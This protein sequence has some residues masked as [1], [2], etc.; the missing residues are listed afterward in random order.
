MTAS[1]TY[2]RDSYRWLAPLLGGVLG[3]C[4]TPLDRFV[5]ERDDDCR[6]GAE[7]GICE[8]SKLCSFEDSA[9]PG[10]RRYGSVAGER[11]NTCVSD[12]TDGGE[13]D[14]S[15]EIAPWTEEFWSHRRLITIDN[16][17]VSG[18][19]EL[20]HFPVLISATETDWASTQAG[21]VVA[22]SDD[23]RFTTV[24]G[25]QLLPH[26]VERY[27]EVQGTLAAWVSVPVLSPVTD[28]RFFV[29]YGS[30]SGATS[31]PDR[32]WNHPDS[33][34]L[35]V[36]HLSEAVDKH[37]NSVGNGANSS[38]ES[39]T[40]QGKAPGMIAGA[41]EFDGIDDVVTMSGAGVLD[42]VSPMS[43]SAWIFPRST[44]TV[45]DPR[46]FTKRGG[47][48]ANV[49]YEFAI[50][51]SA[52]PGTLRFRRGFG[53]YFGEWKGPTNI[54]TADTWFHVAVTYETDIAGEPTLYV[55]GESVPVTE[56]E[57]PIGAP[58]DDTPFPFRLGNNGGSALDRAFDGYIDEARYSNVIRPA[59]WFATGHRNQLSP[60][61]FVSIG[62]AESK[63]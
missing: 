48:N 50:D 55:N 16:A 2:Q 12:E 29:Y 7:L 51:G 31:E 6:N 15:G 54:I 38:S 40:L 10:G 46:I 22:G 3:A 13:V 19:V 4:S 27:D 23:F 41:D 28:T 42:D 62:A 35:A 14:A 37:L 61:T 53:T 24:D 33:G 8:S 18:G 58:F 56:T 63:P 57:V 52:L 26:E 60:E 45:Q 17:R 32:A 47:S 11:S 20:T 9:C 49:G 34:F 30:Q 25:A 43:F 5:C 39:V 44:G 1:M 36:W 59:G 21:G